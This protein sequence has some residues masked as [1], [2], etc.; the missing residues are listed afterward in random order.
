MI[1]PLLEDYGGVWL[2]MQTSK[3][4]IVR[5]MIENL[6]SEYD[7]QLYYNQDWLNL[8]EVRTKNPTPTD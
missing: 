5:R 4:G 2:V 6:M 1:D 8:A 3:H 7:I